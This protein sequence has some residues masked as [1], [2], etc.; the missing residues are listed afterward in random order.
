MGAPPAPLHSDQRHR[1]ER[2]A[3]VTEVACTWC[4][5][6]VLPVERC[7]IGDAVLHYYCHDDHLRAE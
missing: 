2:G 1:G 7:D 5:E 4:G 6:E 3:T